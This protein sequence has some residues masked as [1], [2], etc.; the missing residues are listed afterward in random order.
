MRDLLARDISKLKR[1]LTLLQK[2]QYI[3]NKHGTKDFIDL[4]AKDEDNCHVL[5]ELKRSAAASRQALHEVSKY[6]E[7]TDAIV[8]AP[9]WFG[10]CGFW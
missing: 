2:E 3:H 10:K 5:I 1:G 7:G 4:Y 8:A 9:V 6:I